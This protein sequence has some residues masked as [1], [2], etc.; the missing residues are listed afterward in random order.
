MKK[1]DKQSEGRS[2]IEESEADLQSSGDEVVAFK[3]MQAAIQASR[4]DQEGTG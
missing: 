4:L 3:S 1:H 2:E